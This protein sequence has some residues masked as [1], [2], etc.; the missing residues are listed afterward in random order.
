MAWLSGLML[1]R[2][3]SQVSE[4]ILATVSKVADGTVEEDETVCAGS[5]MHMH[6]NL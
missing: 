6:R 1:S 5:V 3:I 4:I 2:G